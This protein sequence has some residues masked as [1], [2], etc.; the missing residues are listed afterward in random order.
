MKK[1]ILAFTKKV[2]K[3]STKTSTKWNW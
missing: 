2:H 1:D 3:N